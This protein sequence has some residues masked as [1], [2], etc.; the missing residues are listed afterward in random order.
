MKKILVLGAAGFL[1]SHLEHRMKREGHYV[2]SVARKHPP[3]RKSVADEFNFLDL[4][5]VPDFHSHFFRHDFDECYQ[6]A[7]DV[8]GLGHIADASHDAAILTNS[9][10]IN[11]YTLE[12]I[13]N[14]G[15]CGKVFFSSSQCVY[16]ATIHGLPQEQDASFDTFAFGQEKLYAEALY[17]AYA[18]NYGLQV[19]VGRLSNTYGPYCTW[20]GNRSK[21]VAAICRKVAEAPY[22]GCVKLWGDGHQRRSFTYVD[23]VIDGI[24]KLMESDYDKPLNISIGETMSIAELFESVCHVANKLLGWEPSE[25]PVG[26][27]NRGSDNTLCRQVLGWEPKTQLWHGLALTYPWIR[28]QVEKTLTLPAASGSTL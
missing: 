10:K 14:T 3:F 13:K 8:G 1:G 15:H 9:L 12:A 25:G 27:K 24:L 22:A 17:G 21:A 16:P 6:L 11:L 26:V 20:A 4:A 7:G 23:D 5:N 18:R 2:V 19:R 28:D